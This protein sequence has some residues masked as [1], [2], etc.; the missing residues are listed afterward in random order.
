M[1][2]VSAAALCAFWLVGCAQQ[3]RAE[4]DLV[5]YRAKRS[6]AMSSKIRWRMNRDMAIR[7]D[8]AGQSDRAEDGMLAVLQ[9]YRIPGQ[10]SDCLGMRQAFL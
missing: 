5:A 1:S 2:C 9:A 10:P 4:N 8:A 3:P 7:I 6:G